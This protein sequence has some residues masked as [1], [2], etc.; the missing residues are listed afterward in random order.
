MK[1]FCVIAAS[2]VAYGASVTS[3]V[4]KVLE[5]LTSLE[6]KISAEGE[7]AKKAYF[8]FSNWCEAEAKN[9]NFEITTSKGEIDT[10]KATIEKETSSSS[11]LST[12]IEELA[13]SIATSEA[14]LKAATELRAKESADFAAEEKELT[15]TISTLERAI[16]ILQREMAKG[17][18]SMI[19]NAGNVVQALSAMV[20]ASALSSADATRLTALVQSSQGS[21][22][23]A[24]GAPDAAVYE[25]HSGNIVDTL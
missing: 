16:A 9:F 24:L 13:A 21:E 19:Q 10:L 8:E 23:D 11:S 3:P 4:G 1:A 22:D 2:L 5:L 25:S 7:A 20:Q 15:E 17:G 18:A 14:D 12:K 6:S